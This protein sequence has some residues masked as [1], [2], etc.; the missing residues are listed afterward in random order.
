MII[1]VYLDDLVILGSIMSDLVWVKEK[2]CSSFKLT[3][4]NELSYYLGVSFERKGNKLFLHQS[5]YRER[6]L[7]R[8]GM[9]S[10]KP[11]QTPMVDSIENLFTQTES[12]ETEKDRSQR[13]LYGELMGSFL[14]LSSCTR[15]GF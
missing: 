14:Y 1:L 2:P 4:L 5:A 12:C 13:F 7:E 9:I 11:K 3:D 6:V 15:P 10:D 8:F